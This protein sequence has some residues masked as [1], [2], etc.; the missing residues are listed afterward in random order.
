[1][2][3]PPT[4]ISFCEQDIRKILKEIKRALI[5]GRLTLGENCKRFEKEFADYLGLRYA[6][7]VASGTGALEIILRILDVK[8]KEVIVPTNTFVATALAVLRAGSKV[9]FADIDAKTFAIDLKSLKNNINR[10]TKGVIVVHIGGIITPFIK[11]IQKLCR[12]RN[13]FLLEDAAHALGSSLYGY[14]PGRFSDVA[15]FS[16]FATKVMT[17]AE[18]GM[19]V[20]DN[21]RIYK[22]SLFYRDQGKRD[23]LS[24][25][26][27]RLGYNWRM[28]E[29]H[30]IVGRVHLKRL[31]ENIKKRRE[32]AKIYDE[33]F[34]KISG[35]KPL[36]LPERLSYN[37]Y[38]YIVILDKDICR[39]RFKRR[40]RNKFNISLSSEVF[41]LPCHLQPIFK[42]EFKKDSFPIAE[43]MC[44]RHICLPIYPSMSKKEAEYVIYSLR[45]VIKR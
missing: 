34:K 45:K 41:A 25:L 26:Y 36:V 37:Y 11:E 28:S 15:A 21:Q 3:I 31:E 2:K 9:R 33:G 7:S 24:N 20:T 1:M 30:A 22:E 39:D 29:L 35:A 44:K 6:V 16:F 18:G 8:N 23:N 10:N 14:P 40:L 12:D 38:K 42:E 13:L 27:I 4:K 19:I 17:T 43:E 32:I 5:S